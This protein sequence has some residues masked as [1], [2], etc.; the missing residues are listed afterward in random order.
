M[1]IIH[2][3]VSWETT[4]D[5]DLWKREKKSS[6]LTLKV[7]YFSPLHYLHMN[8]QAQSP[9]YLKLIIIYIKHLLS[10]GHSSICPIICTSSAGNAGNL[11]VQI[12]LKIY[13]QDVSTVVFMRNGSNLVQG[14]IKAC[15]PT[16]IDENAP[17]IHSNCEEVNENHKVLCLL[18]N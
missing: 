6:F 10:L 2:C 11:C 12:H 18:P 5:S 13:T 4:S 14:M 3:Q 15:Q 9:E 1:L 16:P 17:C 7:A 8:A